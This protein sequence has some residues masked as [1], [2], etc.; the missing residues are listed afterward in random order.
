MSEDYTGIGGPG[1]E[2]G[3]LPVAAGRELV[4]AAVGK[5]TCKTITEITWDGKRLAVLLPSG[6]DDEGMGAAE[7]DAAVGYLVERVR[8]SAFRPGAQVSRAQVLGVVLARYLDYDGDE[9]L[10]AAAAGLEEANWHTEAAELRG[11]VTA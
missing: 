7:V 9:M 5:K 10:T 2:M 4:R 11:M 8:R 6:P 1:I 3:R